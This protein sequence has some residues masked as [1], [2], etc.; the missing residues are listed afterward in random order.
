MLRQVFRTYQAAFAGLPR[1]VWLLAGVALV[2]RSGS[3]VLPFISLYL[4]EE[5][6]FSI[7]LAG[8]LL[9]LYGIGSTVGSWLG[10]WSSDRFGS[11]RTMAASLLVSGGCFVFLGLQRETWAIALGVLA[12]AVTADAFRPA[13][14]ASM[15]DRT[16]EALQVRSFALLRLAI[17]LGLTVGPAVGGLL[18]V[19]GYLWLFLVD[20]VT[21]WAAAALLLL[22]PRIAGAGAPTIAVRSTAA[23][24]P[25]TDGPFL[26]L[27]GLTFALAAV[28]FQI[29]STVPL[30][31]RHAYALREDAIGALLALNAV[32]VVLFEMVL[33]HWAERRSRVPLIALG[34]FLICAGFGLM[35]FGTS[36]AF[37]ALTV[38]VWSVGEMLSLPLINAVV[39]DRAGAGNRGRY[40]G[41]YT[42]S[43]STA[44]VISPAAGT[45]VYDRLGR[46]ELWYLVG[47]VGVPLA[48]GALALRRPLSRRSLPQA[49]ELRG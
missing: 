23:S 8:K 33:V 9:A 37:A 4:T 27:L 40:M 38:V 29:V 28:F 35:P 5:R 16:P 42:M 24:S 46:D 20:G 43:F 18:A 47:L 32:I 19:R 11:D 1:D 49:S 13:V 31:L 48:L 39:A 44:F 14:M 22:R 6:G 21:S 25:W 45:W 2:N 34:C 10:G 15:A 17:N 30:Y 3:M 36:I 26:A 12:L 7:A 41:L